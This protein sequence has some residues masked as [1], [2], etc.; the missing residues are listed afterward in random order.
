[1]STPPRANMLA[2]TLRDFFTDYLPRL[3]G[4]SAHTIH[5]YRDAL[6]LLLRFMISHRGQAVDTLDLAHIDAA[7]VAAFLD[8]LEDGRKNGTTTRN[9]RLAALHAFFRYAG[10]AD[11]EQLG[12]SQRILAIP[13][14]R[15]GQRSIEYFEQEELQAILDAADRSTA[16]GRR[17]Y[18]LLAVLFNTGARVQEILDVRAHDLQLDKPFQV[19]LLGKR[20]KE[21]LCP[22]WPQTAEVLRD[23][24][25]EH[26]IDL[27][28]ATPVFLNHRGQRLTRFGVRYIL[29]KYLRKTRSTTPALNNKRLHPHSMRHSTA[30]HL[31]K[32]GVDLSTICHW[33]GHASPTTTNRYARV[34][35]DMKR[36]AL[37]RAHPPEASAAVASWRQDASLLDWLATL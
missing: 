26:H 34:D 11:P 5:S 16:D 30:V 7:D 32:A 6:T 36:E 14:K 9:C 3:R 27:R 20:R 4:L 24:C 33:L 17:D 1:M 31:L 8:H 21:R 15:A 13:F 23:L 28:T 12:R 37:A 35:L 22:L 2:R 19:R 25:G 10:T 18:A 29:E